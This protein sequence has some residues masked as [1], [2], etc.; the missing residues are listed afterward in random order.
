MSLWALAILC[1]AAFG[2]VS[3]LVHLYIWIADFR[4]AADEYD[5]L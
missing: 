5:G 1:F 3:L 2:F 4:K